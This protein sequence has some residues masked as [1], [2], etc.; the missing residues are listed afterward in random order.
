M[1][2]LRYGQL[3]QEKPGI[4][5]NQGKIR[6]LSQYVSDING[7]TISP[8]SLAKLKSLDLNNLPL[9]DGN[10]RLAEP[11]GQV[12]KFICVGLNYA[13]HATETGVEVPEEP[14]LFMKATSSIMGPNDTVVLPP[15]SE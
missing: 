10:P 8:E 7:R 11:V 5:D 12:G 9:V 6:D 3:G 13:D 15:S 4:L 14:V 2:L 1:K